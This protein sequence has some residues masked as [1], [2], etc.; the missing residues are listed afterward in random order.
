MNCTFKVI[1]LRNVAE[2]ISFFQDMLLI[3]YILQNRALQIL[4]PPCLHIIF[5]NPILFYSTFLQYSIYLQSIGSKADE[6]EVPFHK[7]QN[8]RL[9][10]NLKNTTI[11]N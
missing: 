11:L 5:I 10:D 2:Q 4:T 6:I 1:S 9:P 8:H 3:P 7:V